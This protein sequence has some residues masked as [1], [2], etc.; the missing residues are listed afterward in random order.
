MI[1]R[2]SQEEKYRK[3][4]HSFL[5]NW[6]KTENHHDFPLDDLLLTNKDQSGIRSR[7][8]DCLGKLAEEDEQGAFILRDRFIKGNTILAVAHKLNLSPDQLNRRQRRALKKLTEIMIT[9][10]KL[11]RD[12][13]AAYFHSHLQ[14]PSY[15][16]L[17]GLDEDL[18]TL[19]EILSQPQP[20]WAITITGIGGIGKTALADAVTRQVLNQYLFEDV[21]WLRAPLAEGV[22][23]TSKDINVDFIAHLADAILPGETQ[24]K[25]KFSLMQQM[26]KSRPY[27]IVIDNLQSKNEFDAVVGQLQNLLNPSKLLITS[28]YRSNQH[29]ETL[30]INLSELSISDSRKLLAYHAQQIGLVDQNDLIAD[31]AKAIYKV[32]GGNPLALKLLVGLLVALPLSVVL[33]DFSEAKLDDIERMYHYIYWKA[34]HALDE[35]TQRL[36]IGMI[37]ASDYGVTFENIQASSGLSKQTLA[38]ALQALYNRSLVEPRGTIEERRYGIHRLTLSF[39]QTDIV[40]WPPQE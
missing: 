25:E 30:I 35:P 21:I 17:V 36:L 27:L 37:Q 39:L 9:Q 23:D 10:E 34:W 11:L 14:A 13:R 8:L 4:I 32:V 29:P 33:E 20:P 24:S 16:H 18:N 12:T 38:A 2:S 22:T 28:R 7:I 19:K 40:P 26:L 5:R 31:K 6:H 3:Q 15:T 1:F